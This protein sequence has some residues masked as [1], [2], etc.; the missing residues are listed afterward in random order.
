M[1]VEPIE[2]SDLPDL[3]YSRTAPPY[4]LDGTV[5]EATL[6]L[7]DGPESTLVVDPFE[8]T[9]VLDYPLEATLVLDKAALKAKRRRLK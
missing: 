8:A 3:L 1:P 2:I 5:C 9:L 7:V 4:N 6:L